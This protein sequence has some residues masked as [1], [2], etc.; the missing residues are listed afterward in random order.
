MFPTV[1]INIFSSLPVII[2]GIE[3]LN[4]E[5]SGATKLKLALDATGIAGYVIAGIIPSE[6]TVI[7]AVTSAVSSTISS[8]VA[9]FNAAGIFTTTKK[10]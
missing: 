2:A 5:A 8:I 6:A 9:G 1:L 4:K 3:A 10:A 7:S